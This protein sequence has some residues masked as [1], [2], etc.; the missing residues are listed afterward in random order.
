MLDVGIFFTSATRTTDIH[1]LSDESTIRSV[2]V[3]SARKHRDRYAFDTKISWWIGSFAG[4]PKQ[5]CQ[6]QMSIVQWPPALFHC[7]VAAS[8]Y[9]SENSHLSSI[10][11]TFGIFGERWICMNLMLWIVYL[12]MRWVEFVCFYFKRWN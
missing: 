11:L 10:H 3:H 12:F 1:F 5:R 8:L 2:T 7:W 9:F 6:H 4:K